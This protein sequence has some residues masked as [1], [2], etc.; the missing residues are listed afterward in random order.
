MCGEVKW[1]LCAGYFGHK[2]LLQ[3]LPSWKLKSWRP[4]EANDPTATRDAVVVPG[5]CTQTSESLEERL[6]S[7][8]AGG[9]LLRKGSQ[10]WNFHLKH[11]ACSTAA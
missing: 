5:F 11:R 2:V 1:Y 7:C 10:S 8:S 4:E 6:C 9:R 3:L